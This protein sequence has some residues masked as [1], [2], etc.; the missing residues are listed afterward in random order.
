MLRL[1]MSVLWPSFMT[2]ILAEGF[3]FSMFDP[4]DLMVIKGHI[5]LPPVAYRDSSPA[6]VLI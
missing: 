6:T 4:V 5:D 2:A 1:A 3:F